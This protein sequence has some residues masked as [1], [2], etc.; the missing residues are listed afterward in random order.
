MSLPVPGTQDDAPLPHDFAGY[1]RC[2]EGAWHVDDIE[3]R[4]GHRWL[5]AM[6]SL[7]P[8]TFMTSV[9]CRRQAPPDI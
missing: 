4:A 7:E 2:H 9:P 3:T 8:G 5:P 1:R 6:S